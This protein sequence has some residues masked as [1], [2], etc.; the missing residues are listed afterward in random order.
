MKKRNLSKSFENHPNTYGLSIKTVRSRIKAG[1][2]FEEAISYPSG[3]NYYQKFKNGWVNFEVKWTSV[4]ELK[5]IFDEE[6]TLNM[7]KSG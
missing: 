3:S 1:K 2:T 6:T 5:M 4:N 7:I